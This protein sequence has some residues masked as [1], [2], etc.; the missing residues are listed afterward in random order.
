MAVSGQI[1]SPGFGLKLEKAGISFLKME[2]LCFCEGSVSNRHSARSL[3][4]EDRACLMSTCPE[5]QQ[6]IEKTVGFV[7]QCVVFSTVSS[8]AAVQKE[9]ASTLTS[10]AHNNT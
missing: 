9:I 2:A 1:Y 7:S 8:A 3:D 6:N 4:P 5:L 10:A